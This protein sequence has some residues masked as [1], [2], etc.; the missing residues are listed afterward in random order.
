MK[1]HSPA[2]TYILLCTMLKHSSFEHIDFIKGKLFSRKLLVK[3]LGRVTQCVRNIFKCMV[4]YS[5]SVI[6][7]EINSGGKPAYKLVIR[8]NTNHFYIWHKG[9]LADFN[10]LVGTEGRKNLALKITES[11]MIFKSIGR[12]ICSA[13]HLNI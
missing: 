4:A 8:F 2:K 9:F 5:A 7:E 3:H 11:L 10:S 1:L 12:V 13:N 6:V